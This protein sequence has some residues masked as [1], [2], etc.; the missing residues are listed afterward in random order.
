MNQL[1][2]FEKLKNLT[3]EEAWKLAKAV[4]TGAYSYK[5]AKEMVANVEQLDADLMYIEEIVQSYTY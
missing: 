1:E 4:S 2:L 3:G 5:A